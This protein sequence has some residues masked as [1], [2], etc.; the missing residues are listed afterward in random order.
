MR[1]RPAMLL[2]LLAIAAVVGLGVSFAAWG[3]LEGIHQIQHGVFEDLPREL[4]YGDGAPLWW[5][6]PV[7]TI[8]GL[9]TALAIERL[10]GTGGHSPAGGLVTG[11][12]PPIELP[13]CYSPPRRRSA[14]ASCWGPRRR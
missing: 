6:L 10:P 2:L 11:T 7:L 5:P 14:S 1:P 13:A 4:G 8:A 9:I 12:T 3:F